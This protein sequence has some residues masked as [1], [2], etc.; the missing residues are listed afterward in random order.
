MENRAAHPAAHPAP[1]I[2]RFGALALALCVTLCACFAC[3]PTGIPSGGSGDRS[4]VVIWPDTGDRRI[5]A[6]LHFVDE[7]GV[8][9]PE[10]R[11]VFVARDGSV[12]E[13]LIAEL[14]LGPTTPGLLPVMPD[15]ATLLGAELSSDIVTVDIGCDMPAPDGAEAYARLQDDMLI[16]RMAI[17]NTLAEL[18]E[19]Q[20]ISVLLNSQ[21][22]WF[23]RLPAGPLTRSTGDSRMQ[24]YMR[25][26]EADAARGTQQGMAVYTAK[27]QLYFS[28]ISGTYLLPEVRDVQYYQLDYPNAI[29][30]ALLRGPDDRAIMTRL[31]PDQPQ[32]F[33]VSTLFVYDHLALD[34]QC[35]PELFAWFDEHDIDP[36]LAMG[37]LFMSILSYYPDLQELSCSMAGAPLE[38]LGSRELPSDR[39]YRSDFAPLVGSCFTLYLPTLDDSAMLPVFRTLGHREADSSVERLRALLA[40]PAAGESAAVRA[41]APEGVTPESILSVSMSGNTATVTIDPAM[42]QAC[43]GM[44]A[45][46]ERMMVYAIVNTLT[47]RH[48]VSWVRFAL[49]GDIDVPVFSGH[50]SLSDP[51]MRA[52]SL[53]RPVR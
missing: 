35:A 32:W 41:V 13:A 38:K 30:D 47:L 34:I 39:V 22:M 2:R 33:S 46:E 11:T 51:L 53:I 27:T 44:T 49:P 9:A 42:Q 19:I 1:L 52:P 3:A 43:A 23:D 37:S 28:D 20:Y 8:L 18:A 21:A 24:K 26:V 17:A 25:S 29:L 10:T 15:G 48:D 31:L 36:Y 7:Q 12:I 4:P 40:G 14:I 45:A 6:T 5:S 16:M 50:L